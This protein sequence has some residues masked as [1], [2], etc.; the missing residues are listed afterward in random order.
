MV[1]TLIQLRDKT[2]SIATS[3]RIVKLY[4]DIPVGYNIQGGA[5][6]GL[7][8]DREGRE[9]PHGAHEE[10]RLL[11]LAAILLRCWP[12]RAATQKQSASSR[13]S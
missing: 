2:T 7:N 1:L 12:R 4:P 9:L 11:K 6:L 13:P 5:Q 10:A 8:E 3:G